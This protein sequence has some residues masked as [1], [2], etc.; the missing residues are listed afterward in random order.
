MGDGI[1]WQTIDDKKIRH[2]WE[3]PECDNIVY[4]S[5]WF[6]SENGTP[7]CIYCSDQDMEYISTQIDIEK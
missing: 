6:Y 4:V 7:M 2:R 5:P 1:M 3:C